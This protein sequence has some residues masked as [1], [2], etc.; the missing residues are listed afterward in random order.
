MIISELLL[1]LLLLV[2]SASA[3]C[4][5]CSFQHDYYND[6][7]EERS[8][9]RVGIV[10]TTRVEE[11][12]EG[13]ETR[14]IFKHGC[15]IESPVRT[16][17]EVLERVNSS[18]WQL[19]KNGGV[20]DELGRNNITVFASS[21]NDSPPDDAR[22]YVINRI[23]PGIHRAYDWTD[24]T[25]LKT[26]GGGD[27]II[28]Q[29]QDVFGSVRTFVNCVPLNSSSDRAQNG[30]VHVVDGDLRPAND[31]LLSTLDKDPRFSY[32]Y[33]LLSD[34]LSKLLAENKN[35]TVFVPSEKVFSSLSDSLLKDIK[36]GQG[37]T[38]S[39]APSHIVEGSICS[40]ELSHHR[41]KSLAGSEIDVKNGKRAT[42]VGRARLVG[43]DV[44]TRNGVVHIIDDILVN[45][46]FLSWKEHLEI[47]NPHL[48]DALSGVVKDTAK[49]ITIFVPPVSNK[50]ISPEIAKNHI[51]SGDVLEDFRRPSSIE[52]DAKSEM[53]TG[54]SPRTSP[55]WVRFSMGRFQRQLGQLGCTRIIRDSVRGCQSILHFIEKTSSVNGSLTSKEPITV[56]IPSDDAFSN[57]EF[58]KLLDNSK[59]SDIFVK[60]Y[61]VSE[62]LCESDIHPHPAEIRIQPHANLNGE[63]LRLRKFGD[64][65]FVDGAKIEIQETGKSAYDATAE[66]LGEARDY[67]GDKLH[68]G[69]DAVKGK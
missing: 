23:V 6:S 42:Y 59:L 26:T 30:L 12:C 46:E 35:F 52:T 43:G 53:F 63:P 21:G 9:D 65:T 24:G 67:I 69:A 1:L 27:L 47:Y 49:L 45:D 25:V 20:E 29:S 16:M 17:H 34:R 2:S 10:E 51:V 40:S 66:K 60:R 5:I 41:L 13:Y 8:E 14:D 62:P 55:I 48:S 22:S 33:K 4:N 38:S 15:P 31:T 28:S 32:F 11:C 36:A 37:C 54:Y 39:F 50:T 44:Y 18:L 3:N 7:P 61:I 68:G 58:K 19:A 64:D 57:N 56:F